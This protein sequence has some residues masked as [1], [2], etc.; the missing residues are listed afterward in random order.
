MTADDYDAEADFAATGTVR[1]ADCST[2]VRPRTLASLPPHN[3][4]EMR[5]RLLADLPGEAL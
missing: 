5:A 4:I 2:R 3:C 1:C